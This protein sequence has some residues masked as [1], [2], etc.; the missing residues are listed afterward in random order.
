MYGL[1][2]VSTKRYVE[3][4]KFVERVG[5]RKLIVPVYKALVATP[6][7]LAF[8]EQAFARAKPGYHPITTGTVEG[9]IA[10][11]KDKAASTAAP[12]TPGT[13]GSPTTPANGAPMTMKVPEELH[14][15]D[16]APQTPPES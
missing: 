9:V 7:G 13:P 16:P 3:M 1:C 14:P 8:A 11:A 2:V 12:F 4:G 6:D 5:R 10:E 15:V